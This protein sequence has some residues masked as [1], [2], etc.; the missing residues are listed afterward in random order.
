MLQ[1]HQQFPVIDQGIT[2]QIEAEL[3]SYKSIK[4]PALDYNVFT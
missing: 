4:R 3:A 2:T 1:F